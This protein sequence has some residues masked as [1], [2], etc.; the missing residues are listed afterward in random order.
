[1]D[2]KTDTLDEGESIRPSSVDSWD[3]LYNTSVPLA[4]I[5]KKLDNP[6]KTTFIFIFLPL[7]DK[8][9]V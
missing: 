3:C 1:M 2:D 9:F 4:T 5:E 8:I 6:L 7:S